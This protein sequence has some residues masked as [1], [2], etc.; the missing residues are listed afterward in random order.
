MTNPAGETPVVP[1]QPQPQY[2]APP[3]GYVAGPAVKPPNPKLVFWTSPTGIVLMLTAVAVLVIAIMLITPS[4]GS[5]VAKDLSVTVLSCTFTGDTATAGLEVTNTGTRTIQRATLHIE[6]RD[7]S[8]N[9][10]DTDTSTVRDI[11]AGDTVR[12]DETTLLNAR[13]TSGTCHITG[14]S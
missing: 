4:N 14:I 12:Q 3:A 2:A 9:R 10:I 13:A 6:Y 7:S 8:G 1:G 11:T 5:R